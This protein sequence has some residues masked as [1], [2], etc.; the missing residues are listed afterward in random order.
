MRSFFRAIWRSLRDWEEAVSPDV[1]LRRSGIAPALKARATEFQL[2]LDLGA[3][4]K[5]EVL[6]I[7][8]SVF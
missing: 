6:P 2:E 7:S 8:F 4:R 5:K 3:T 1:R